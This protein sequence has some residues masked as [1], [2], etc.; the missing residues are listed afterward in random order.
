M[1][2]YLKEYLH[3]KEINIISLNLEGK[4]EEIK[5]EIQ[6]EKKKSIEIAKEMLKEKMPIDKIMKFTGLTEEEIEKIK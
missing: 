1:I 5:G 6:G 2:I 3:L 4:N